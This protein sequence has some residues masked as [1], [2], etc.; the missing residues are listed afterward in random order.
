MTKVE[1]DAARQLSLQ[2]G[3]ADRSSHFGIAHLRHGTNVRVFVD[4]S[5]QAIR[6]EAREHVIKS[7]IFALSDGPSPKR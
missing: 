5:T 6:R 2:L 1:N 3:D 7:G 4:A